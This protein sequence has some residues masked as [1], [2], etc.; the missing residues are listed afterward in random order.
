MVNMLILAVGAVAAMATALVVR[1]HRKSS[2]SSTASVGPVSEEWL[3][4]PISGVVPALEGQEQRRRREVGHHL[5][6]KLPRHRA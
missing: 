5:E 3:S 2:G 1:R 4:L 6:S